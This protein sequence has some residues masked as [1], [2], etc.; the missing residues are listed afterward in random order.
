MTKWGAMDIYNYFAE[1]LNCYESDLR[2]NKRLCWDESIIR[3]IPEDQFSLENWNAFLSYVFS[4]QLAFSSVDQAKSFL[5]EN[6]VQQP[7]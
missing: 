5:I 2:T 3:S 1:Q 6:K 4:E 7:V